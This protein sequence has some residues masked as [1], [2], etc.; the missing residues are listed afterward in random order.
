MESRSTP[1]RWLLRR[2]S[3]CTY[4]DQARTIAMLT[5]TNAE[6]KYGPSQNA[7]QQHCDDIGEARGADQ[8][9]GA[10]QQCPARIQQRRGQ[11]GI[12]F[13]LRRSIHP[14]TKNK[15]NSEFFVTL[16][17]GGKPSAGVLSQESSTQGAQGGG[18]GPDKS[19]G[20]GGGMTVR[21]SGRIP[22]NK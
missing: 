16:R 13:Q 19:Q 1:W 10:K 9:R 6:L 22:R 12:G 20:S 14:H 8:N 7:H 4:K 17:Q 15:N 11:H 2:P 5:T 21:S 3:L 18:G